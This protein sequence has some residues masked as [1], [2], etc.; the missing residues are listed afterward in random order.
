MSS[1][2]EEYKAKKA[3]LIAVRQLMTIAV[4]QVDHGNMGGLAAQFLING[5]QPSNTAVLVQ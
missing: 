5:M 4:S 1:K 2:I 3:E